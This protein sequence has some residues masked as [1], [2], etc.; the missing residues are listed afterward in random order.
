M[1]RPTGE[2]QHGHDSTVPVPKEAMRGMTVNAI[3]VMG[4][5]KR[6]GR[7]VAVEELSFAVREGTVTAFLGPNGSGKTTTLRMLL[8]LVEPSAG[9]ATIGGRRYRELSQPIGR[10][11]AVLESSGFHPA[12]R[13]RD[14]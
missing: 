8:G 10:V 4:L 6:F 9:R 2:A 12:R 1:S 13:A 5:T 7:I 14:H 11:G 3:E